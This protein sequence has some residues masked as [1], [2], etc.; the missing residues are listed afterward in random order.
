LMPSDTR[1]ALG[2]NAEK[3]ESRA[4]LLDR[5]V[6]DHPEIKE[7]RQ[8]HFARVRA[9][10]FD[11]IEKTRKKWQ[12]ILNDPRA[13]DSER[14]KARRF[15]QDTEGLGN[16]ACK[17][18]AL[19]KRGGQPV[20]PKI[21]GH[22]AWAMTLCP[23]SELYAQLRSR[24]T[25]NMAG[26]VMENAGL[27][28]DRFGVPYIPGS[29]VK[30][31]ARRAAIAALHEWCATGDKPG[32]SDNPVAPG[33]EPFNTP[34]EMLGAI[35]RVFGWADLDW[36]DEPKQSDF[37]W[38][39][40]DAWPALRKAV[41]HQLAVELHVPLR[42]DDPKPWKSLPN[43]A[44]SF[45]FLPAYP[46]DLGRTGKVDGLPLQVPQL[47]E[48]ELDV[49]TCHHRDYYASDDPNAVATDT[50]DPVPVVFP[51]VAPGHVFAFVLAPVRGADPQT[52]EHARTWLK[53]GLKTFGLGAK[54][55]AG[56]GWFDCSETVQNAVG[57]IV[58]RQ[59]ADLKKKQAE[60]ELRRKA[61]AEVEAKA[62]AEQERLAAA[63]AHERFKLEYSKLGD[64]QFA[65]QAKKFSE[66]TEEQ[67]QGFVLA[68]KARRETARRW[69]K[70]KPALIQ[71]WQEYAKTLNP[72]IELP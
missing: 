41:V 21:E 15:L 7:A 20:S 58:E 1:S 55:N 62:R 45:S 39:C 63:P 52:V 25:V 11:A 22:M 64:E 42:P 61:Q 49:V 18:P 50:E 60:A 67:R 66:M 51:A 71:P 47:G 65:T 23:R 35:A 69:A 16:R 29:V 43:V 56:Y 68:L 27:C 72:T 9:S 48:L 4:L 36:A 8:L 38:A 10:S 28:L 6:Y 57:A 3:C 13:T 19:F 34:E 14:A 30:G 53:I 44:G 2:Q 17:E 46:V 32:G 37:A 54:T 59:I 40:G 70:K 26:G 5:F 12:E 31:C 33:C 24:L